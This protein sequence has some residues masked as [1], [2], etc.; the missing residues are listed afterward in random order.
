M[1]APQSQFLSTEAACNSILRGSST[2]YST[3]FVTSEKKTVESLLRKPN[4]Y[5]L[6]TDFN[7]LFYRE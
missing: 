4:K 5:E 2:M 1:R 6:L 3:T 7:V